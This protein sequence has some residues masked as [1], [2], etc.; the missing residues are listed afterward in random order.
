[1]KAA[2]LDDL[3][4]LVEV[5]LFFVKSTKR[6]RKGG[7]DWIYLPI[8]ETASKSPY[9]NGGKGRRA[10]VL[11]GLYRPIFRGT[12]CC[13]SWKRD[14]TSP[15]ILFRVVVVQFNEQ[16]QKDKCAGFLWKFQG[17]LGSC[18]LWWNLMCVILMGLNFY[19]YYFHFHGSFPETVGPEMM[20]CRS[21]VWFALFSIREHEIV[22]KKRFNLCSL[23]NF[24]EERHL[25]RCQNIKYRI[26]QCGSA[27]CS[28]RYS[29]TDDS[30]DQYHSDWYSSFNSMT[31]DVPW[32][33]TSISQNTRH[34]KINKPS[35]SV[36]AFIQSLFCF[37]HVTI[38][39]CA[40]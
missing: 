31:G 20:D 6:S 12:T 1:M 34:Q 32:A 23:L 11:L 24:Q 35:N 25:F 7:V 27:T 18:N 38:Y 36:I 16:S 37:G 10:G 21:L 15:D 5:Q 40:A 3:I 17:S 4:C 9:T 14:I 13:Y 29:K 39:K 30:W 33:S 8:P 28:K 19:N 22:P 2:F 26:I